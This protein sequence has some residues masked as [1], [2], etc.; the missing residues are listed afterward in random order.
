[1]KRHS[2]KLCIDGDEKRF[3]RIV[4]VKFTKSKVFYSIL[5]DYYGIIFDDVDSCYV[6]KYDN[7]AEKVIEDMIKNSEKLY[8]CTNNECTD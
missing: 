4:S 5:D 2:D 7:N 1:M 3:G 8:N 6:C